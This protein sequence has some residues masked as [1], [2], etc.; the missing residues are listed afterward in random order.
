MTDRRAPKR[1]GVRL[2][3]R[4][5]AGVLACAVLGAGSGPTKRLAVLEFGGT[6]LDAEGRMYLSRRVRGEALRHLGAGWQ[7]MDRGNMLV[8]LEAHA[9]RCLREGQCDVETF[10]NI[11]ADRGCRGRLCG[12]GASCGWR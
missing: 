9:G 4:L 7:V 6:G 5:L 10:R 11:G 3:A 12:W 1:R 2:V 8:L